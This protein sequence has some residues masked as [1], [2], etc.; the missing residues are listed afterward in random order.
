MVSV[1]WFCYQDTDTLE[2]PASKGHVEGCPIKIMRDAGISEL[3]KNTVIRRIR[4]E[5]IYDE[6]E[7]KFKR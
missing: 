6:G 1:C 2:N 7:W 5:Q 4:K 3:D